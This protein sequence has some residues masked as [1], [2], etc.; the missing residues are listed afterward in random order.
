M[1]DNDQKKENSDD[2]EAGLEAGSHSAE[3]EFGCIVWLILC[4]GT[5]LVRHLFGGKK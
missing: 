2:W 4:V 5:F 3:N 1:P